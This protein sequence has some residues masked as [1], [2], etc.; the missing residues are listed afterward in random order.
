MLYVAGVLHCDVVVKSGSQ[1]HTTAALQ[2]NSILTVEFVRSSE[3]LPHFYV[4]HPNRRFV[5]L[6][7]GRKWLL[8]NL[9]QAS[10]DFLPWQPDIAFSKLLE[11]DPKS[12]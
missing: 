3:A 9:L 4:A 8:A 10:I 11:A 1:T 2:C 5:A 12:R 7:E 6:A